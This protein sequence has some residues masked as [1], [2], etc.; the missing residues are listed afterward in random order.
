M[1]NTATKAVGLL[2]GVVAATYVLGGAVIALRMLFEGFTPATVITLLGQLP[3]QLVITTALLDVIAPAATLGL[4]AA[5]AFGALNR[6][7]AAPGGDP[8]LNK[9]PKWGVK[10]VVL[11]I[12]T[13]VLVLPAI[14]ATVHEEGWTPWLL[15]SLLGIAVTYALAVAGLYLI[16]WAG[17]VE[18]ETGWSHL[19][20][21]AVAGAVWAG[22][23]L[24]PAVMLAGALKFEEAQVCTSDSLV[25]TE[26][27]LIGESDRHVLLA[28][29]F[30]DEE[31]VLSL[32]AERV[33]KSEYG[34]LSSEF[35][36]PAP[37]G[38]AATAPAAAAA[39]GGQGSV[40]E[41]RLAMALRP[42]LRFDS[43][44]R[45]RPLEVGRFLDEK[46]KDGHGQGACRRGV[47]P[48]C[49]DVAGLRQLAG[50]SVAYLDIHGE[51]RNGAGFDSPP[52]DCV[53]APPSVDCEGGPASVMYYRRT[54][55]NGH[56]YWDYWWFLR[57]ND[58]T[59]S[60]NNCVIV[61]GDHEGDWEGVTVITTPSLE[62]QLLGAVYA[63][64]RDRVIVG[65]SLLPVSDTHPIAFVA[66]GTH[67]TYPYACAGDCEQYAT[68]LDQRLPEE[69]HDGAVEWANNDD[70][71]CEESHCVRPLPS[72]GHPGDDSPPAA[73]AWAGWPGHWGETCHNGCTGTESLHE[74]SPQSPGLQTRFKCPWVPTATALPSP[75]G[76]GL[77]RSKPVGDTHRLLA[78]CAALRGGL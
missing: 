28:T 6:P 73:G 1:F 12:V 11:G 76:S 24:V 29:D 16:R 13:L 5:L 67:A 10:F 34:D 38:T 45:W 37:T 41:R 62:P 55:H 26:G 25:E 59:G 74:S 2:A 33:T 46:F 78:E 57:Y 15:T 77:S 19:S 58:Y 75:D 8:G 72:V 51:G 23:A 18:W 40:A 31:S 14:Y 35:N 32:P 47:E 70:A 69:G 71:A 30:G 39:L 27:A 61:C 68:Q 48:P 7:Q 52:S 53:R 44:E 42:Q 17:L 63:A 4:I 56:W 65:G 3:R 9:G 64:H 49:P 20:K 54:T 36:C 50:R 60:F 43:R 66:E 22:V 21:A